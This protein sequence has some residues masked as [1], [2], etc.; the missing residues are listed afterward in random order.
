MTSRHSSALEHFALKNFIDSPLL[1]VRQTPCFGLK[2][3]A[4]A[5]PEE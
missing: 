1:I 5:K 3:K 4:G 2:S